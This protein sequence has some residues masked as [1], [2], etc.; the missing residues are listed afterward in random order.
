MSGQDK[1]KTEKPTPKKIR[2]ARKEGNVGQSKDL[3]MVASISTCIF[4]LFLCRHML[5][6]NLEGNYFTVFTYI[7]SNVFQIKDIHTIVWQLLTSIVKLILMI[8]LVTVTVGTI[9]TIMQLGGFLLTNKLSKFDLQKFNVVNNAKQIFSKKNLLKFTFNCIKI[10]ILATVGYYLLSGMIR[11]IVLLPE[12]SIF[13]IIFFISRGLLK[14][15]IVLLCIY[16]I[17]AFIDFVLEK[18]TMY[19]QLMM[20]REEVEREYKESD[21]NPEVKHRRRELHQELLQEDDMW[22]TNKDSMFVLANPTHIAIVLMYSPR[23][24]KLP[25]V[26]LKAKGQPAQMIFATAKRYGVPIFRE[27]WTARKLYALAE[28]KKFIPKTLIAEVA[29]IIGKNINL[30]PFIAQEMMAVRSQKIKVGNPLADAH[31]NK[32]I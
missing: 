2:D 9:V 4:M 3:S 17:F 16:F 24:Y 12:V 21:G 28:L 30:L 1:Q 13:G 27:K 29:E 20:T 31:A 10:T 23:K 7:K 15:I 22:A 11:D 26:M 32:I 8:I 18:R 14:T 19:K 6:E 5:I 25:I